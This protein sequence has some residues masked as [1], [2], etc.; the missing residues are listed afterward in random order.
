MGANFFDQAVDGGFGVGDEGEHTALEGK[1]PQPPAVA[2]MT[3]AM[4]HV[5][6]RQIAVSDDRFRVDGGRSD[7]AE[8]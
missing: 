6:L 2:S 3:L 4:L 1:A 8:L 5:L 7:V